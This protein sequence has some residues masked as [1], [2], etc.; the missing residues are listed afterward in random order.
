MTP[1]PGG[2]LLV[3]RDALHAGGLGVPGEV[4]HLARSAL[5]FYVRRYAGVDDAVRILLCSFSSSWRKGR[6]TL[7]AINANH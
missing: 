7:V 4:R 3:D 5:A 1:P 2:P 6:A